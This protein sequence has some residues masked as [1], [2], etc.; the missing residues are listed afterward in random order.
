MVQ[1]R[2]NLRPKINPHSVFEDKELESYARF[3]PS[4]TYLEMSRDIVLVEALREHGR[5]QTTQSL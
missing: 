5:P 3:L 2:Q 1:C 4:L